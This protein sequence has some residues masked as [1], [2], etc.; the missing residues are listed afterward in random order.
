M[1]FSILIS[2]SEAVPF[3][4]SGGLADVV[5]SLPRYLRKLGH[6]VRIVIPRYYSIDRER[7]ALS[8]LP[9]VLVVPM[10]ALGNEYCAVYEGRVPESDIP[11]YFLEHEGHYGRKGLYDVDNAEFHDNDRR[12]IFL[13]KGSL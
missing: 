10:G 11:V 8:L 4:K 3:A 7:F 1:A 2:A 12:F 9:G 13:S 5:G 6:D